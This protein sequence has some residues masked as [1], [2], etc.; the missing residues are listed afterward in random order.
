MRFIQNLIATGTLLCLSLFCAS[1]QNE[2]ALPNPDPAKWDV[3]FET[4][5]PLTTDQGH[6]L[7]EWTASSRGESQME[8]ELEKSLTP[9]FSQTRQIYLG[10]DTATFLS[11]LPNGDSWY[12][13]RPVL[14][15]TPAGPWS[16]PLQVSVAYPSWN[17]VGPLFGSGILV[18]LI[19]LATVL[20]GHFKQS[21]N[22][23]SAD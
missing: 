23:E 12:R 7:I 15:S 18:L 5:S 8:F 22:K 6:A 4:T 20:T 2:E 19:L 13:V 17:L 16:S 11:G 9:D 10:P 14:N 21:P 3:K 1:A